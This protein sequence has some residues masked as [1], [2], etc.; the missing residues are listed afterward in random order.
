[1]TMTSILGE[2]DTGTRPAGRRRRRRKRASRRYLVMLLLGVLVLLYPVGATMWN[3]RNLQETAELY[4]RGVEQIRPSER[5]S[6]FL[7]GADDYNAQLA[8]EGH[9]PRLEDDTDPDFQRYL[10]ELNAPETNGIMARLMIPTIDVD[11]PVYH[12]TRDEVLYH[13]AGHMYGSDLPVGGLGTNS[14]ITAHT[15][16]VNATMFDHLRDLKNGEDVYLNVMGEQLIYR[17]TG[18]EVVSPDDYSAVTYVPDLDK[19]T[20]ITCTPYGINS[21]RLL[22][23]AERVLIPPAEGDFDGA[24]YRF[25]W[26]MIAD[27]ILVTVILISVTVYEVRKWA[28]KRSAA[29]RTSVP[30][31]S[32]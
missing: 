28:R 22:V 4:D 31:G 27:L 23:T 25:S 12:T 17:V 9:P 16:M 32:R 30:A 10:S 5:V 8:R 7:N 3:D 29:A 11:L 26:W 19:I 1:M 2:K 15:G 13:G 18:R 24:G 14:V 20:L 6:G 21:D